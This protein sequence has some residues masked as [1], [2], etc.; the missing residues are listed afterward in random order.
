[1]RIIV[2]MIM[3]MMKMIVVVVV[4]WFTYLPEIFLELELA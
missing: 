2:I 3:F 4:M 1:M